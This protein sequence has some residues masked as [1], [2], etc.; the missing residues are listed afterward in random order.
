[1]GDV[2]QHVTEW[3]PCILCP[4]QDTFN[5]AAAFAGAWDELHIQH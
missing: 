1:M 4:E 2:K 3:F 5:G